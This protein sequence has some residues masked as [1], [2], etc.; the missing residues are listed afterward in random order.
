[1]CNFVSVSSLTAYIIFTSRFRVSIRVSVKLRCHLANKVSVR[2]VYWS[3]ESLG[4]MRMDGFGAT[5]RC[6]N[7]PEKELKLVEIL[8]ENFFLQ[9]VT[10]ATRQRGSDTPHHSS[11]ERVRYFTERVRNV[12]SD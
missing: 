1:M 3:G 2:C 12:S 4:M 10:E 6:A 7:L 11:S 5:A 9:H 8:R